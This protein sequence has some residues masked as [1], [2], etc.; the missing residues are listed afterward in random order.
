[1]SNRQGS[2]DWCPWWV[3]FSVV[4]NLSR[5]TWEPRGVSVWI[6]RYFFWVKVVSCSVARCLLTLFVA[7]LCETCSLSFAHPN[8]FLLCIWVINR[9]DWLM[10]WTGANLCKLK[11]SGALGKWRRQKQLS[12]K[13]ARREVLSHR[14]EDRR[15]CFGRINHVRCRFQPQ[16]FS[17]VDSLNMVVSPS[18]AVNLKED[19]STTEQAALF[20]WRSHN[21]VSGE[22]HLAVFMLICA[23]PINLAT[24]R[25]CSS[26]GLLSQE[27]IL[28]N[29]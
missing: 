29:V 24:L 20:G 27:Y 4:S 6:S 9:V 2:F 11:S 10:E 12:N 17:M 15:Y 23:Y 7:Y 3:G 19:S 25:V 18:M 8:L 16:P 5:V 26:L 22:V 14:P 1:M 21:W 13:C 28:S